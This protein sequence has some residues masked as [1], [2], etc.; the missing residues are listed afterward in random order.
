MKIA[1]ITSRYP[2]KGNPYNHM[3]VHMRSKEF[4]KQGEQAEVFVPSIEISDYIFEGVK[5]R[6]M[7]SKE[8]T[9]YLKGYD[10]LYLHLLHLYPLMKYDGWPIYKAIMKNKYP[11]AMYVHG[12][13]ATYFKNRY[14]G[15]TFKLKDLLSLLR[16]DF[17]HMPRL[18]KFL[19]EIA[20]K[21]GLIITPSDWMKDQIKMTFNIDNV[22]AVPNGIDVDLFSFKSI[23]SKGRIIAVRP[24]GDKV[25]D[26]E[27]TIEVL[28]FLPEQYTLNIYGKGQYKEDYEKLIL[29]KGLSERIKIID[30]FIDRNKMQKLFHK[31]DIFI[32]TTKLDTQGITMLEA[33]SSGLLVAAINNSSKEEFIS[34]METGI[35]ANR[36]KELAEKILKVTSSKE[37]FERITKAG[38]GSM[39]E[40]DLKLTCKKELRILKEIASR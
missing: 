37:L 32:S 30:N 34:D 9:S 6:L 22:Y 23:E 12:S 5:V 16:K 19:Q 31:Y 13:E 33:M 36:P 35:L 39:E 24:L 7:P 40:I 18:K 29:S 25:Y 1:I 20:G 8:I 17:Y 28:S 3:F 10:I 2:S 15:N 4:I 14:F 38:R 21:E 26:I 27:C 11:F